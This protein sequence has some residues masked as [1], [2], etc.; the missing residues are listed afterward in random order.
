MVLLKVKN[1]ITEMENLLQRLKS[2]VDFVEESICDR[3]NSNQ[4]RNRNEIEKKMNKAE[5]SEIENEQIKQAENC[6]LSNFLRYC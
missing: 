4:G 6:L 2:N 5:I 3:H 1:T